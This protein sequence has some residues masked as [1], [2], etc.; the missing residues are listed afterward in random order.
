MV[1]P[2]SEK[3]LVIVGLITLVVITVTLG[4]KFINMA[5]VSAKSYA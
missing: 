1:P 3:M 4:A 5:S 2:R